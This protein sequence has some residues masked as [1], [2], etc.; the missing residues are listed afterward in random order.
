MKKK[1]FK[2]P[3]SDRENKCR[4]Y[5]EELLDRIIDT[6]SPHNGRD[7]ASKVVV[8]ENN[9]RGLLGDF[10]TGD[11]HPARERDKSVAVF[12]IAR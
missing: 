7:D 9:V 1:R 5:L 8:H 12:G 6:A 3:L 4:A 2:K 10:S 11:T